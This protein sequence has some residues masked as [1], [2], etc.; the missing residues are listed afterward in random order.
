VI[1]FN[2]YSPR[3]EYDPLQKG[4]IFL[5]A[6]RLGR[7]EKLEVLERDHLKKILAEQAAADLSGDKGLS[8]KIIPADLL[9]TGCF[10]FN[11]ETFRVDARVINVH[12]TE[13]E[14]AFHHRAEPGEVLSAVTGTIEKIARSLSGNKAADKPAA[15]LYPRTR[16]A[17]LY[18]SRGADF[19]DRGEY[20]KAAASINRAL[21]VDPDYIF[22]RWEVA[23]IYEE[24]LGK[25]GRALESYA[26]VLADSPD[27][28][29]REK[30]L[31]RLAMINYRYRKDFKKA[32][33]YFTRLDSEFP[34]S[35]YNDIVLY[36]LGHCYQRLG[37]YD[38]ALN[39]YRRDIEDNPYSPLRGNLL[40]RAGQCCYRSGD[41][42]GARQFLEKARDL[43]GETVFKD[44]PGRDQIT[45]EEATAP[46]LSRLTR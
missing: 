7:E 44:E 5:L 8:F 25:Y 17:I 14:R 30:T 37:K 29:T 36:S 46:Y 10:T 33:E 18:F 39:C 22:G 26:R 6:E 13:I 35:V 38:Q 19:Y 43:Y 23:R 4:I 27:E 24:R 3:K 1:G 42:P 31:L 20:E 16:E 40:L 11:E 12:T 2:N 9:V 28:E 34:D 21:S 41:Y 45:I 32:I 15:G